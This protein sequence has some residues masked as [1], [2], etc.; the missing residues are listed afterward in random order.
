MDV[1]PRCVDP[2]PLV[3]VDSS[4]EALGRLMAFALVE[5]ARAAGGFVAGDPRVVLELLIGAPDA[6]RFL[7]PPPPPLYSESDDEDA[8]SASPDMPSF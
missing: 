4:L 6:V 5:G 1:D 3:D 8:D 7:P 2:D